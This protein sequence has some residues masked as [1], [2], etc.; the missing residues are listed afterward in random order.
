MI[1]E[2]RFGG[3]VSDDAGN[4]K[5]GRRLI[6]TDYPHIIDMPDVCHNL[7]NA[8]K[9]LCNIEEFKPVRFQTHIG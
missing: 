1:G 7:H 5:K 8:C 6:C 4:T 3:I 2:Y 9:D